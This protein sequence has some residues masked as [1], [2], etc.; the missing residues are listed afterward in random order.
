[1]ADNRQ[2][3]PI[4]LPGNSE[5]THET[6]RKPRSVTCYLVGAACLYG[7]HAR[8]GWYIYIGNKGNKVTGQGKSWAKPVTV[9][10]TQQVAW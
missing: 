1:M 10:V 3:L 7:T 8:A 2:K 5:V 9:A 4:L 6:R